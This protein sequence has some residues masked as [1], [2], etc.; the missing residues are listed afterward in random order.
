MSKVIAAVPESF[1]REQ[2]KSLFDAVGIDPK[3]CISLELLPDGAYAT[4]IA[5]NG[6]GRAFVDGSDAE[7][8]VRTHEVFVP[9]IDGEKV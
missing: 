7:T 8:S 1:T 6:E 2:W 9:V 5:R 3:E 4:I